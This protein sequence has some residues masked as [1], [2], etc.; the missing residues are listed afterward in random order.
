MS[1]QTRFDL[2][3]QIAQTASVIETAQ[4]LIHQGQIVELSALQEKIAIICKEAEKL[5]LAQSKEIL[6]LLQK[7]FE[8][9]ERLEKDI[10]MQHDALS[11]RLKLREQNAN[12]LFAQEVQD[13]EDQ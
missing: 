13:E 2:T 11:E 5:P 9:T 6:P 1:E 3:E 8:S 4:R 10:N 12:P 7:L